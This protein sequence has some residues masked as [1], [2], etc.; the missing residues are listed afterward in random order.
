MEILLAL[1][2]KH[3]FVDLF[4]QHAF[5]KESQKNV[6]FNPKAHLHYLH[7]GVGSFVILIWITS[8]MIAFFLALLDYVCHWHI[9]YTK[10]KTFKTY[11]IYSKPKLFWLGQSFDQSLHYLTYFLLMSL[12][13]Q[14]Q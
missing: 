8:P 10:T 2:L 12:V 4:L 3:A 7:H 11:D 9:D 14:L 1:L 13:L 5:C 6:Y